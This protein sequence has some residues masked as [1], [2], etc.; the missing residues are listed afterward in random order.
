MKTKGLIWNLLGITGV[1]LIFSACSLEKS[2]GD[3]VKAVLINPSFEKADLRSY[4][5]DIPADG[6]ELSLYNN[7]AHDWK[8]SLKIT[9][10]R[11]G[12]VSSVNLLGLNGSLDWEQ[13]G[14]GLLGVI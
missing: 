5:I 11:A 14:D 1:I 13:T 12:K 7:E 8:K 9:G 2:A 6:F 3:G 10:N 4:E